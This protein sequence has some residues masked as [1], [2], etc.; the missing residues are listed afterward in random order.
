LNVFNVLNRDGYNV[1]KHEFEE[2]C[3]NLHDGTCITYRPIRTSLI[4]IPIGTLDLL[5]KS[6]ALSLFSEG[7]ELWRGIETLGEISSAESSMIGE[8]RCPVESETQPNGA[9]LTGKPA[10]V[11]W[12]TRTSAFAVPILIMQA[13]KRARASSWFA[14]FPG[15]S[16]RF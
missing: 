15:F 11:P 5:T 3:E 10:A 12:Q 14:S 4:D 8:I 1:T 16:F 2:A 6:P 7:A 13:W 9:V